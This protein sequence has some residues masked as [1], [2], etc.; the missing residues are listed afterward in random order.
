MTALP[1]E[2]W[3]LG[4]FPDGA[5]GMLTQ[6]RLGKVTALLLIR[7]GTPDTQEPMSL[8]ARGEVTTAPAA[9]TKDSVGPP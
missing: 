8:L 3:G 7:F 1:R 2:I 6:V 9:P 5:L 4:A